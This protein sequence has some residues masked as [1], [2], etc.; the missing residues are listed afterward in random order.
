MKKI[1]SSI[2]VFAMAGMLGALSPASPANA[3]TSLDELL[4][5]VR[6]GREQERQ[7]NARREAEF[8]AAKNQQSA[9]LKRAKDTL[10]AEERR[11]E[12][13]ENTFKE[14]EIR[15]ANLEKLLSDRLGN[16]GE[17][18]GIMRQVAGDTR[19]QVEN[20]IISA[21]FPGRTEFLADLAQS[22]ELPTIAEMEQL[23]Y[24][25]QKEMTESAKVSRF[26]TTVITVEGDETVREV[27]RIGSF[28]AISEGQYLQFLPEQGKLAELGRQPAGRYLSMAEDFEEE[29]EGIIEMA[30]DPSRG[31]ILALLIQT[32]SLRERV[33]QGGFVGYMIIVLAMV[34][35]ALV[36]ERMYSLLRIDMAVKAQMRSDTP[37]RSNP[38][39][40]V[41]AA[42]HDNRDADV[43]T[44]ELKLDEAILQATPNLE[45]GLST[46]KVL[47]AVAPLMGLLGTVTGMI[48][49]FQ[50][51][52]LFGTGDPKLMAGGISQA[53]VTTVLGLL[54][55]IPLVL[56]HSVVSSRSKSI[57]HILEEQAA[58]IVAAHAEKGRG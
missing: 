8:L 34:G 52:T 35:L 25:I 45:R 31:S 23:W 17:L 28:N 46:I 4:E 42:Y 12:R 32:P 40:H 50:A 18:F 24:A 27:V 10:A 57:V 29:T 47:A 38:L 21:E 2:A 55:A 3:A 1:L 33:D 51:I 26:T 49:T 58:G 22:K 41:L 15:L 14:N 37:D 11:S 48:E 6:I 5:E 7:R 20:S 36:G 30:I 16:L 19:A 43:E 54:T 53:L 13:L 9:L 39:G 44:M 56:L